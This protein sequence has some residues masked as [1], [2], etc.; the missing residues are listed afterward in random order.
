MAYGSSK[1]KIGI[2]KYVGLVFNVFN[3]DYVA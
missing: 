2:T 1:S 3:R